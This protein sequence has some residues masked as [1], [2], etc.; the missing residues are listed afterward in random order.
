MPSS[1]PTKSPK[2]VKF[3]ILPFTIEPGGY[4]CASSFQGSALQLFEPEGDPFLLL[5]DVEDLEIEHVA[6]GHELRRVPHLLVPTH[7]ADVEE[8]FQPGLQLDEDAVLHYAHRLALY[9]GA[10]GVFLVDVAPTG[11]PLGP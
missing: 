2:S 1:M 10:D 3:F 7:L 6:F 4:F 9:A 11:L 8:P 5:I